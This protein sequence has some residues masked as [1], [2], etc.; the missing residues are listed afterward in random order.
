MKVWI[1][2][3]GES[4]TNKQGLWTGW[5][6]V[7]LTEK[8]RAD[9]AS[10]GKLLSKVTFDKIFSSDLQRAKNTAEIAIPG[11]KYEVSKMLREINVGNIAGKPLAVARGSDDQLL[12]KDGYGCFGGESK[13]EFRKRVAEFMKILESESYENVAVFSHA[14]FVRTFLDTVVGIEHNRKKIAC[15]NCAIAVFEYTNSDWRLYSWIN[16]D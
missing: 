15:E 11:C 14:G 6:D 13:V 8:G 9:A 12:T 3:H 7:P 2:R 4:E 1:V 5:L 16:L 10:A